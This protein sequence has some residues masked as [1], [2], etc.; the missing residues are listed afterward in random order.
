MKRLATVAVLVFLVVTCK[1]DSSGPPVATTVNVT[2]PNVNLAAIGATQQLGVTVL[3]Q[4]G[5]PMSA[6]VT[7]G[8]NNNP[9]A[10]VNG[11]G[12]VTAA[13][14][15]SATITATSGAAQG[16][17]SVTVAQV[18]TAIVKVQGDGQTDTVGQTLPTQLVARA[19]DALGNPVAGVTIGYAVSQGSGNVSAPSGTTAANGQAPAINFTLGTTAG[20]AHQVTASATGASS[21]LFGATAVAGP[22][23]SVAI[24]A[25]NNQ[26]GPA[27]LALAVDPAVIVR[28]QFNNVSP[29]AIVTFAASSGGGSVTG[30]VD[31]TLANGIATVG[32]W[33]MGPAGPQ[34]LTATVTGAG[35]TGNPATFDATSTAAGSPA[36]VAVFDGDAQT[37]LVGYAV[38]VAPGAVVR[39]AGSAPVS[40]VEVTFAVT[41]GGGSLVK[42]VDT[43]DVTGVARV[44]AWVLGA[45][46]GPNAMTAT[47]TSL[48]PATF[49][50]TGAAKQYNIELRFLTAVSAGAQAA[51]DSAEARW[52]R[53]LYGDLL[54]FPLVR[55][56][57]PC[58]GISVPAVNETIDDLVIFVRLDSI[59]GPANQLGGAGWC[60]ARGGDTM[61]VL[62]AAR[63]DTADV[64]TFVAQGL[65]DEIAMHEIGHALGIGTL[66]AYKRPVVNPSL[67]SSPGVDTHF[68]GPE[69]IAA[70][71]RSGGSG[72]VAG[73]KVPVANDA[74][75]GR[76]D[77]HWR[78]SVFVTE[79]MSPFLDTGVPNPASVISLAS[80]ADVGYQRVNYAAADPYV[81]ANPLLGLAIAPGAR[82]DFG[83]DVLRGPVTL[84]DRQGRVI[85]TIPMSR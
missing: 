25:G 53:M 31:T 50:A 16:T 72:Y 58:L 64:A 54:D 26:T 32:S 17:A 74:V 40:N 33:V 80:L 9:V 41:G 62:G 85:R 24:Q 44:G 77:A 5:N 79:L 48:T 1:K 68:T 37:G 45:A 43:T 8:S 36:T 35:V 6:I 55:A 12:L 39:D 76:A 52:E 82:I 47:V 61:P 29:N 59:D 67:P 63:F 81:V 84:I 65:F 14:N 83:A 78:E 51:F 42:A 46:A 34:Q 57:G 73:Q 18:A 27:G 11:G 71:D 19:N 75:L 38:N 28:D 3:D 66:W 70:F 30:G 20:A 21:A 60:V 23:A 56:A 4:N 13:A 7:W 2:P 15:G 49:N 69:A 22:P 10:T